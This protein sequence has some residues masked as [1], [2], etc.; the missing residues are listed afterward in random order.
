V[1]PPLLNCRR[2]AEGAGL[3]YQR[4]R[5]LV[6]AAVLRRIEDW[7]KIVG[8]TRTDERFTRFR[9]D[10]TE[11]LCAC[12]EVHI[13]EQLFPKFTRVADMRRHLGNKAHDERDLAKRLRDYTSKYVVGHQKLVLPS[14]GSAPFPCRMFDPA[15]IAQD[16]DRV[17]S[18]IEDA[19]AACKDKGG[20]PPMRAFKVLA[21]GLIRAYRRATGRKGTGHGSREGSLLDLVVAVLPTVREIGEQLTRKPL[22]TPTA[23]NLSEHLNEIAGQLDG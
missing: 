23:N 13:A 14:L 16:F 9:E 18:L 3:P 11:T 22:R 5:N 21:D 17:A 7:A 2:Q 19:A 20:Q 1:L 12:I 6:E 10:L 4:A 15:A 8:L